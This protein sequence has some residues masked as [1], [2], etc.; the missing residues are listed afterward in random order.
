LKTELPLEKITEQPALSITMS[1][2]VNNEKNFLSTGVV[3][4]DSRKRKKPS[5]KPMSALY[6]RL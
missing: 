4:L 5:E 1:T 3:S 6:C 2:E